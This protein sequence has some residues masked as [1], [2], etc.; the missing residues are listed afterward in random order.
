VSKRSSSVAQEDLKLKPPLT[1][2]FKSLAPPR[3]DESMVDVLASVIADAR[4]G[5]NGID[6]DE[7]T[8]ACEMCDEHERD[9]KQFQET[10]P[11]AVASKLTPS[12]VASLGSSPS[13]H[14]CPARPRCCCPPTPASRF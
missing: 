4:A 10:Q 9:V 13:S 1:G 11:G 8:S 2:F 7:L 3:D 5:L 12:L 14:S 6:A